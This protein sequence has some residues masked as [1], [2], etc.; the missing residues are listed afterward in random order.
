MKNWTVGLW[1]D[2]V[3][4]ED[5][6]KVTIT[7]RPDIYW[8]DGTPMTI[9]DVV[10][11]LVESTPLLIAY[12]NSPPW[13]WPT[14]E[15]VKS[16]SIIDTYTVEILYDVASFFA[17][18]WTLGGF[19]IVP[20]HIWKPLIVSGAAMNA[21]APDPNFVASGP[22]RYLKWFPTS[23]VVMVANT[24]G[25]TV[26]TDQGTPGPGVGQRHAVTSTKGYHNYCPVYVNV[27][28]VNLNTGQAD[29][30][31]KINI[32]DRAQEWNLVNVDVT[33]LN[34]WLNS[35]SV[36]SN[37]NVNKNVT[38]DGTN[39]VTNL[40]EVL[41]PGVPV[42][43]HFT[44]WNLT[45]G[46]HTVTVTV[47]VTGPATVDPWHVNPWIGQVITATL[48]IYITHVGDICGSTFYDD[49]GDP[50]YPFK[51]QLPTPDFQV[52]ITDLVA[53][54]QSFGSYP[55][56]PRWNSLADVNHDYRVDMNDLNIIYAQMG[57][58]P[59]DIAITYMDVSKRLVFQGYS[60]KVNVTVANY[61]SNR[62]SCRLS[63]CLGES[64][65]RTQPFPLD[66]GTSTTLT[67][68]AFARTLLLEEV[69]RT[70][71]SGNTSNQAGSIGLTGNGTYL[72]A[73]TGTI[74][75][76]F[77]HVRGGVIYLYYSNGTQITRNEAFAM[78][79]V[80]DEVFSAGDYGNGLYV[81]GTTDGKLC[82]IDENGDYNEMNVATTR[83]NDVTIAGS[84][85]IA[86]TDKEDITLR[87]YSMDFKLPKGSFTLSAFLDQVIGEQNTANNNF[88]D[89]WIVVSM[90][91]DLTGGSEN[92]WDFVP[93]G[94]VDGSDLSI[95]AKCYGS[96]PAAPPPMIWNANC[97]VNNDGVVDGSD[98]A[99]IAK[100]F[101]EGSP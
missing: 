97:D 82:F 95:V 58:A 46:L 33:L 54:A 81:L 4:G 41:T 38:L 20:K 47:I 22:M 36:F 9:A 39:V 1:T 72:N 96:W 3:T 48:R 65:L 11:S 71:P 56:Y 92:P 17:E 29:Y 14:S 87:R 44:N 52:D 49:I 2:P 63:L 90:V 7:L 75:F 15:L 24:A 93:D 68:D 80:N 40:P 28:T 100:H 64:P 91:G 88:T 55:G 53:A 79:D 84:D 85:V 70:A 12:G 86:C 59:E 94:V 57:G 25:R 67:F 76:S 77:V 83:I 69:G 51:S 19:Y 32:I 26:T 50:T 62:Q 98:L 35:S 30:T 34:K 45:I 27:H 99:I 42:V 78:P 60:V 23:G 21:F 37:L 16:L 31:A 74:S 43:E 101:G 10:F 66:A 73:N 61:G 18:V 6:S 89:G 13:W 5:K 8:N